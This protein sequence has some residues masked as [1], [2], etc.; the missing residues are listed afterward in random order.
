YD[1]S[2]GRFIS[3]DSEEGKVD[4]P[5]SLN[6]Y[7]YCWNNPVRYIDD[8]GHSPKDTLYKTAMTAQVY[9]IMQLNKMANTAQRGIDKAKNFFGG[10]GNIPNPATLEKGSGNADFYVSLNGKAVPS[11]YKNWIGVSQRNNLLNSVSNEK[12]KNAVNQLYRKGSVIGDG[13]T[14]DIIRFERETGILLSKSGHIQKGKDM[15]G[16]LTDIV[17]SGNLSDKDAKIAN[18]LIN[19]LQKALGGL[20]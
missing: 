7:T 8:D 13:G 18:R 2:N 17:K 5:L 4:N 12:L 6:L 1:P 10:K 19:D 14:A 16:Y 9:L 15:L 20:K 11:A 3:E